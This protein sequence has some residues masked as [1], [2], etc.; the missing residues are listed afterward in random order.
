MKSLKLYIVTSEIHVKS[1]TDT[2]PSFCGTMEAGRAA[3][4]WSPSLEL[5]SDSGVIFLRMTLIRYVCQA[6][7]RMSGE[8]DFS[9]T[10]PLATHRA[11]EN[12]CF[13]LKKA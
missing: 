10:H 9:M 1:H 12:C 11:A 8:N 5:T 4:R 7:F 13:S 3:T 2:V 6:P